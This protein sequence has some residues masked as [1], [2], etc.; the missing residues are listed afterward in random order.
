[1]AEKEKRD[2]QPIDLF[3]IKNLLSHLVSKSIITHEE[4]NR[5]IQRVIQENDMTGFD[6]PVFAAY[7]QSSGA[8]SV[9]T[10]HGKSFDVFP[11]KD[12]GE[13]I[14]L[15]ELAQAHSEAT[16]G[17]VIQSWLRDRTTLAFLN[18]WEAKNNPNYCESAYLELLEK[19]KASSFT[20]TPKLWIGQTKAIGIM[21]KQGKSGG[22]L[23]H[24]TI[25]CEF[26][27]WLTPEF[28]MLLLEL[29]LG[30]ESLKR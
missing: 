11:Q 21:S 17:Y 6:L 16:P 18:L 29:S 2:L 8:V 13:Y 15:T 23:A 4:R 10:A 20:L 25:A 12:D 24:P 14:S 19:K 26:A 30:K 27:S 5:I 7:E 28:K 22:T 3:G 9:K 1:M